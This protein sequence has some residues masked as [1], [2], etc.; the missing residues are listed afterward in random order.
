M[1][2]VKF[3]MKSMNNFIMNLT[4]FFFYTIGGYLVLEN[5]LSLGA[6]VAAM[7]SPRSIWIMV[8]AAFV[9]STVDS[10]VPLLDADDIVRTAARKAEAEPSVGAD[11]R[12]RLERILVAVDREAERHR[13]E[14]AG[15]VGI[16]P[17]L[18]H[19]HQFECGGRAH[20]PA[21]GGP[22]ESERR[23]LETSVGGI[24]LDP[25]PPRRRG[26]TLGLSPWDRWLELC[27]RIDGRPRHL[28]IHVGGMLV[29]RAPLVDI[30]PLEHATMP[31]RVVVQWNK[32][33]VEDA[34]LITSEEV[35]GKKRFSLTDDGR[36]RLDQYLAER[37]ADA[38]SADGPF[39]YVAR[40]LSHEDADVVRS[41]KLPGI[42]FL[43]EPK[44]EYPMAA[45]TAHILGFVRTDDNRGLEGI[46]LQYDELLAGEPGSAEDRPT[47]RRSCAGPAS[48]CCARAAA[49]PRRSA[50][51]AA[52]S[53]P[54]ATAHM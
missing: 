53:M 27:A 39:A 40:Q 36:E 48:A 7:E 30:A 38:L 24:E 23:M 15:G 4:P 47:P 22:S 3:L 9:G 43:S 37:G 35:D 50:R 41:A 44:R 14:G 32:D 13:D 18:Q 5:Q 10:L 45:L 31:G 11:L 8:P 42:Y 33:G 49:A 19:L 21:H 12:E 26:S 17:V 34:G 52:S 16:T 2:R 25:L 46:E 29:T 28:S 20:Q 54:P 1:F 51:S 6:L